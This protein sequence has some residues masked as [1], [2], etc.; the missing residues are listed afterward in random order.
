MKLLVCSP[1]VSLSFPLIILA[2]RY[3]MPPTKLQRTPRQ[4][5]ATKDTGILSLFALACC[6]QQPPVCH[7][8]QAPCQKNQDP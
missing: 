8:K 1:F 7:T 2:L 4:Y 6:S 3:Q 5:T